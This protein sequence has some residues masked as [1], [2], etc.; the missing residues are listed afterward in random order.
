VAAAR[1]VRPF[2]RAWGRFREAYGREPAS[3]ADAL[4]CMQ[5]ATELGGGGIAPSDLQA[6]ADARAEIGGPEIAG[7]GAA[8]ECGGALCREA[9]DP[10]S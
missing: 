7:P 8:M 1:R 10:A 3:E 2:D 4:L 9:L 5:R 6:A